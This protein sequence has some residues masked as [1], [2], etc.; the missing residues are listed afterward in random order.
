MGTFSFFLAALGL[1]CVF[2]ALP[3]MLFPSKM[4]DTMRQISQM[5]ETFL[6]NTGVVLLVLG[7]VLVWVAL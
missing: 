1:A 2:E 4:R 3:C 7:V 5:P 6:R